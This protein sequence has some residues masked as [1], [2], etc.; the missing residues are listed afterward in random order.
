M[1]PRARHSALPVPFISD[2]SGVLTLH[3]GSNYI[4]SQML[5]DDPDFLALAY[6]RAMMAFEMFLPNPRH[7]AIIGLG[8]GSVAKWCHRHHPDAKIT[9]V[10]INPRVIAMRDTFHI[11][12]DDKRFRILCEDAAA[13]VGRTH[14]RFDALLV[15]CFTAE[16]SPRELCS[17]GFF[18]NCHNV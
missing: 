14:L 15:D 12:R 4:Q 16:S 8:G 2:H 13:F 9:A 18:D 7:I 6:T 3:F 17:Q 11:P 10:E 1:P 5:A